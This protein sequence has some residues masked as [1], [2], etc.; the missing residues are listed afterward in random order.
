MKTILDIRMPVVHWHL[1][2]LTI[3]FKKRASVARQVSFS[4]HAM[5][6]MLAQL[7]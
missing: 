2:H 3:V 6:W 5:L 4:S 1:L 7:C